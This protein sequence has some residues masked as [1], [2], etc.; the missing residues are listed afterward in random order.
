M[1]YETKVLDDETRNN[2]PGKF[3]KLSNGVVHYEL[4]GGEQDKLV[5][6][7]HGFS[8]PLMVWDNNFDYLV[9]TGFQ[10]LRYDLYGRGYS[11]RPK[12]RYN[13]P[14][15][16]TQLEELLQSLGLENKS[17]N[18]AGLSMGGGITVEF[19]K[20]KIDNINKISLIDPVGFPTDKPL[21]PSILKVPY[22]NKILTKLMGGPK[23]II[24]GQ[25]DDFHNYEHVEEYLNQFKKQLEY[26]GFSDAILSTI[27]HT[28]FASLEAT[29]RY[30][31]EAGIP[32]QL[33]WGEEDKII[34][35]STS[36]RILK[37]IPSVKFHS[38]P[39]SGHLPQYTHAEIVNPLL[40]QFLKS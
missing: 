6:L 36:K 38:I 8:S 5:V 4:E 7:V 11:D 27:Q 35:Y 14:L 18:V 37:A 21:F 23:R 30:I 12:V 39:N 20:K 34:P 24:E 32:I 2:L 22:I 31:A 17:L 13:Y 29:Y 26:K 3:V 25:K 16:V 15:F 1:K 19:A 40:M 9:S 10:V 28:P 33:F